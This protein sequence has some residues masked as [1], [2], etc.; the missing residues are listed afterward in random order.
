MGIDRVFGQMSEES[1]LSPVAKLAV[2]ESQ[3]VSDG[4]KRELAHFA[5]RIQASSIPKSSRRSA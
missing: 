4:T 3:L 2:L 1:G 5:R